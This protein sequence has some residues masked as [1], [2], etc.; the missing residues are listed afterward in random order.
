VLSI[1]HTY[2][3]E[4]ASSAE[5]AAKAIL[6]TRGSTPRLYRNALV[7]LA[8]DRTR[9]QDLD[10]ATRRYLAWESIRDDKESLELAPQQVKQ[11]EAQT[12]A[13]SDT[14]AARLPETFQWLLAPQQATPHD[15]LTWQAI[16]L[17]GQ[18]GLAVRASKKLRGD[19][20]L[21]P[22]FAATRLRMELDNIPLWRGD[23]VEVRQLID[24]YARY[25]YLSRFTDSSVLVHAITDG[26]GL[27][28]WE[29]EAFAY[30]DDYDEAAGRYI[31]LR[32]DTHVM[33]DDQ[34]A[35]LLVKPDVAR[36]QMD[37]EAPQQHG[38]QVP[39]NGDPPPPQPP[40]PGGA[41]APRRFHGSVVLD[42]ARVG[43][44]ASRIADEVIVHLAGLVGSTV[45]VTVEIEA[46]VPDGVPDSV[47]RTVTEN[48][49]TLGF[50]SQA[51]EAE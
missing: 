26:V 35:G 40:P 36:A 11:V 48:S 42:T 46:D 41:L 51:F 12:A 27:L 50:S 10:E 15:A 23:H 19:E 2:S 33:L 13:A 45:R 28:T 7:F 24:D 32:G 29:T 14:V 21:L 8:A 25:P 20:L 4:P 38:G 18:E 47:I 1:D 37:A 16:R 34:A 44:D 3:K 30:A 43:R 39:P 31:G 5:A 49:R 6:E 9:M 22:V 17:S